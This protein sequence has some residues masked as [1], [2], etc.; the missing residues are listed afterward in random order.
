MSYQY[1][2]GI[3]RTQHQLLPPSL[4][5]YVS[6]ENAVRAID[7]YV[8]SLDMASLGFQHTVGGGGAG[9]PP[10]A[11]GMLL[12]LYVWGYLNRIRSSRRLE[13]ATYRN[14]EAMWLVQ[15]LH[16][17]YKTIANFR[18]DNPAALRAVYKDFLLMCRELD[19]FDRELVGI[20]SVFLEG[21]ASKAS[22]YTE[23]RLTKILQRLETKIAEYLER[24]DAEDAREPDEPAETPSL[25]DKLVALQARQTVM[26]GLRDTLQASEYTQLSCTDPD[27]RYLTK[28]TDKGPT[29]GYN[30]QCAVDSKHKLIVACDVVNDGN[31]RHQLTAMAQQAKANLAV[32]TLTAA[33]DADYY[34]HDE[35][36]AC[37]E[38]GITV[39]V[40]EPDTTAPTRAEDRFARD[41]FTY[42]AEAKAYRCPADHLLPHHSTRTDGG[43]VRYQYRSNKTVCAT[44]PLRS[45]CLPKKTPYRTLYRWEH[46]EVVERHR[47]RMEVAGREY[48]RRRS[49]LAEHPF[50]TLKLW[51][52]WTHFLV[53]GL[54]KVRGEFHLL[55]TCYNLKRVLNI[56]GV[57]VVQRYCQERQSLALAKS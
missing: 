30:A 11:P 16:P 24:L 22:I 34:A 3:A 15:G 52:G 36:K 1:K 17:S 31:D 26:Q 7:A 47:A 57:T 45:Q 38:A 43:H 23:A 28:P 8:D 55:T 29:A 27:A 51:C 53:R 44:C 13:T 54:T 10:Y 41:A 42:E 25:A 32:E 18:K 40:P 33:A 14:L 2:T 46:E 20:D 4:D 49:G 48:M 5:E 6:E 50:G 19:L 12:K 21:D 35:L 39:Y 9:Q 37:E 56:L